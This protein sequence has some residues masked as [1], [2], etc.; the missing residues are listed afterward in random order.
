MKWLIGCLMMCCSLHCGEPLDW[1]QEVY[2]TSD[3]PIEK[4]L[5]RRIDQ[6]KESIRIAMYSLMHGG[7]SRAIQRAHKRGVDVEL[8]VD[9]YSVKSRS[10]LK[11]MAALG[12]PIYVWKPPV[13]NKKGRMH[14]KFCVFGNHTVWTGSFNFTREASSSNRENVVVMQ[15]ERVVQEFLAEYK[16]LK[17]DGAQGY[18]EFTTQKTR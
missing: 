15:G 13:D 12:I 9:G 1:V 7:I 3:Q 8:L 4:H 5:I 10:P 16:L 14:H 2:F 18:A 11:K 17:A 6:E